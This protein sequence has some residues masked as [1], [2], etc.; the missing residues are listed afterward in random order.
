MQH[1]KMGKEVN[2]SGDNLALWN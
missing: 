1:Q 2:W